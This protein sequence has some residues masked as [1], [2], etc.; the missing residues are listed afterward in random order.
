[1]P[2]MIFTQ[3]PPAPPSVSWRD[4]NDAGCAIRI[5][6]EQFATMPAHLTVNG[7]IVIRAPLPLTFRSVDITGNDSYGPVIEIDP[8]ERK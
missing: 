4:Y 8:Q 5:T 3:R 7:T 1:M 2:R 6:A